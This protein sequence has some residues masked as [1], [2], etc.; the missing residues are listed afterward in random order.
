LYIAVAA[1]NHMFE[2]ETIKKVKIN[3]FL[4]M[5]NMI[6]VMYNKFEN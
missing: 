1:L 5:D 4:V 6:F 3:A 2:R